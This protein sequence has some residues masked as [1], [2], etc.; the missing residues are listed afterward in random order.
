MPKFLATLMLVAV[1][2]IPVVSFAEET[3]TTQARPACPTLPTNV[4][5]GDAN[6]S[7][8]SLQQFLLEHFGTTASTT[9]TGF[10]GPKT[11]ELVK[12]FQAEQG[13]E[14]VGTVGPKTRAAI[15]AT[16]QRKEG[17][18]QTSSE[19][20]TMTEGPSCKI[21]TSRVSL[22]PNDPVTI[23]WTSTNADYAVWG[24]GDKARAN[25]ETTFTN[26][27]TTTT[28]T[29]T[30]FGK[31][32]SVTCAIQVSVGTTENTE[33]KLV[34]PPV[35]DMCPALGWV[36]PSAPCSGTW[37]PRYGDR[38]CQIGWQC[39]GS[40]R[41]TSTGNTKTLCPLMPQ[42]IPAC[43]SPTVEKDSNGCI[44]GYRCPAPATTTRSQACPASWSQPLTPCSGATKPRYDVNG[45]QVG[46]ECV[47]T[48]TDT[49]TTL[50]AGSCKTPWGAKVIKDGQTLPYEP[51]FSNGNLSTSVTI[52]LVKCFK[53]AWLLCD[54]QGNSCRPLPQLLE[55]VNP[56][57]PTS[58]NRSAAELAAAFAALQSLAQGALSLFGK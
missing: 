8:K 55:Q 48:D 36:E 10:F 37:T 12:K 42:V 26:V 1:S 57:G 56:Q 3:P 49:R 2:L 24:S 14:Q 46:I 20:K 18:S 30:F 9:A 33:Q 19:K 39:I 32:G 44:T 47:V 29:L 38:G 7:V 15:L 6:D 45:C 27:S 13:L 54:A 21:R 4:V 53:S 31:N 40:A 17:T 58:Y 23:S 28:F 41:A 16:C 5:R 43:D 25:G 50:D 22:Q 35:T 51:Y 52:P 11:Q 34:Q